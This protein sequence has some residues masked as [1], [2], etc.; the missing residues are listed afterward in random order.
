MMPEMSLQAFFTAD[1]PGKYLIT[2]EGISLNGQ[3]I[4]K[5]KLITV[6]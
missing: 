4:R 5:T 2:L 1:E 6:K 3:L